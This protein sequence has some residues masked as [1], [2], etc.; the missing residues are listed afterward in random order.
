M[1]KYEFIADSMI[2]R[3]SVKTASDF[4]TDESV[5]AFVRV[6]PELSGNFTN[7]AEIME[8]KG[9]GKR[10]ELVDSAGSE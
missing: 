8:P 4:P 9:R 2:V 1:R 3:G 6:F 5:V 7:G 10:P